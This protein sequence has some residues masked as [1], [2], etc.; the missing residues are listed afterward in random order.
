MS[1]PTLN[2]DLA[3]ADKQS[4]DLLEQSITNNEQIAGALQPVRV[5]IAA[6][7]DAQTTRFYDVA[8][9]SN[10]AAPPLGA[11]IEAAQNTRDAQFHAI[12]RQ[13]NTAAGL[14]PGFPNK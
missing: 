5:A 9:Q 11:A 1:L 4:A 10:R 13:L 6:I 12:G 7:Q 14:P 2:S 3:A 8:A